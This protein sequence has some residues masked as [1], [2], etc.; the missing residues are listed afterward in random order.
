MS[1]Q[2]GQRRRIARNGRGPQDN[3]P[4][5]SVFRPNATGRDPRV[6]IA[7]RR[8]AVLFARRERRPR[9]AARIRVAGATLQRSRLQAFARLSP[10][11]HYAFAKRRFTS[12]HRMSCAAVDLALGQRLV[13]AASRSVS[14]RRSPRSPRAAPSHF[15]GESC[16]PDWTESREQ[17]GAESRPAVAVATDD[18]CDLMAD[19]G[20]EPRSAIRINGSAWPTFSSRWGVIGG[21][22]TRSLSSAATASNATQCVLCVWMMR[23]RSDRRDAA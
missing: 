3:K 9:Y 13:D 12:A 16:P 11:R 21:G 18:F 8:R 5:G 14:R 4:D 15:A 1:R 10:A 23:M 20:R 22:E 17:H 19:V 6:A 2:H 7:A